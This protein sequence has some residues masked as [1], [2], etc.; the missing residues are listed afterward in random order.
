MKRLLGL[1]CGFVV[2]FNCLGEPKKTEHVDFTIIVHGLD[3]RVRKGVATLDARWFNFSFL[4]VNNTSSAGIYGP[5]RSGRVVFDNLGWGISPPEGLFFVGG[6]ELTTSQVA[7]VKAGLWS[8][9][10]KDSVGD[11]VATGQIAP[12]N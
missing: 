6:F 3:G 9:V 7:Q 10:E 5:S 4:S 2:V 12:V 1:M 11:V 8:I